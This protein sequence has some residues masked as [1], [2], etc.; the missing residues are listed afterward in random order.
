M[1]T[2]LTPP[3]AAKALNVHHETLYRWIRK[4][5]SKVKVI[6]VERY[7]LSEKLVYNLKIKGLT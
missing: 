6:T 7:Q 5:K 1:K 2:F 3:Q 4:N